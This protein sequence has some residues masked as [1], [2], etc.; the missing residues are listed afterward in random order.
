MVKAS[1]PWSKSSPKGEEVLVR[2]A[3]FPSTLSNVEYSQKLIAN[4]EKSITAMYKIKRFDLHKVDPRR[5]W[6][7]QVRTVNGHERKV[8]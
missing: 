7:F 8:N 2:R 1:Q 4:L 5:R 6:S 3:C